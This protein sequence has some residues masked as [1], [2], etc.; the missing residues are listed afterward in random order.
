MGRPT[1]NPKDKSLF[2]RLDHESSEIL[3]AYCEKMQVN[4][5]EAA[6]RGIKML[7]DDLEKNNENGSEARHQALVSCAAGYAADMKSQ[8]GSD[9]LVERRKPGPHPEK[10]LVH[11]L[12]V[13]VDDETLEKIEFCT[14]QLSLTRS[15]VLRKGIHDLYEGLVEK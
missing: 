5:A 13:K 12:K 14:K 11:D 9:F 4:K 2:I 8:L 3:E 6:R 15:E 1:D 10:P 7:K